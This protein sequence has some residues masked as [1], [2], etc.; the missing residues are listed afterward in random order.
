MSTDHLQGLED[1]YKR[2]SDMLFFFAFSGRMK[3]RAEIGCFIG[4]ASSS[5][6]KLS[7]TQ[8][9]ISLVQ[10]MRTSFFGSMNSTRPSGL[11]TSCKHVE[12][13]WKMTKQPKSKPAEYF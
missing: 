1:R 2:Q 3:L 12:M 10:L 11:L 13:P 6:H 5:F 4:R 8:F 7:R 9:R